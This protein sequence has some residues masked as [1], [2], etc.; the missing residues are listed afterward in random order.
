EI[1]RALDRHTRCLIILKSTVTP[2]IYARVQ[3]ILTAETAVSQAQ[4]EVLS[5]PEFLAEGTAV[6][7]FGQPHRV[8]VGA[9][10]EQ[11]QEFMEALYAPFTKRRPGLL[12]FTDPRSAIIT[13]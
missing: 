6:R 8:V 7:D 3:E 12:Q 1:G 2:D 10:S 9:T 5:N 11:A 4:F 13:K